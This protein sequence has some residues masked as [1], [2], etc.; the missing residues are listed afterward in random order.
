MIQSP[1]R[2]QGPDQ[3]VLFR[4]SKRP[5]E[6]IVPPP[7]RLTKRNC[8]FCYFHDHLTETA[9]LLNF[10]PG[11]RTRSETLDQ[12]RVNRRRVYRSEH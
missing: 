5:F 6:P 1:S 8:T 4:M 3:S 9:Q 11:L 2:S 7:P 10:F 12:A